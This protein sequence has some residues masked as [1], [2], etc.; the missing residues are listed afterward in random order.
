ML[1]ALHVSAQKFGDH[2]DRAIR[3]LLARAKQAINE[4]RRLRAEARRVAGVQRATRRAVELHV[5]RSDRSGD[6]SFE[7]DGE[8]P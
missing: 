6:H 4:S 7:I 3:D 2:R 5:H 1:A 8:Q